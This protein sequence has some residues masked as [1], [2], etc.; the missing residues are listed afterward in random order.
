MTPELGINTLDQF[1]EVPDIDAGADIGDKAPPPPAGKY[2]VRLRVKE[3]NW[4]SKPEKAFSEDGTVGLWGQ[5]ALVVNVQTV[6]ED[7]G[8][9]WN[10]QHRFDFVNTQVFRGTSGVHS[11]IKRI[12]GQADY[13]RFLNTQ[14]TIADAI[15]ELVKL[16]RTEPLVS[17]TEV[18]WEARCQELTPKRDTNGN[19]VFRDDGT[20]ITEKAVA[21]VGGK[22]LA[23]M[24]AFPQASD[25]SY[26][27]VTR[28]DNGNEVRTGFK[29]PWSNK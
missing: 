29:V 5:K 26:R 9:P 23:Y 15:T 10:H 6:I 2:T 8:K 18:E 11:L 17:G 3:G 21:V 22:R 28:D 24:K 14:P 16:L 27:P 19:T 20:V 4:A 13:N 1:N 12:L 7:E 25:G